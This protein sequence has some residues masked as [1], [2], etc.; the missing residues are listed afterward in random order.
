MLPVSVCASSRRPLSNAMGST[1]LAMRRVLCGVLM[2]VDFFPV[3]ILS[4]GG[5]SGKL[6]RKGFQFP[7]CLSVVRVHLQQLLER[8]ARSGFVAFD[9]VDTSQVQVRRIVGGR[10]TD[11][12]PKA[13]FGLLGAMRAQVEDSQ[14]VEG[15][16]IGRTGGKR[17]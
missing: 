15:L 7:F 5:K 2:Q 1:T 6:L 17:F 9:D 3:K 14:I 8:L 10:E 13:L 4:A 11:G 16:G 12:V